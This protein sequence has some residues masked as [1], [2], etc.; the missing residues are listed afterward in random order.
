MAAK[1]YELLYLCFLAFNFGLNIVL[2]CLRILLSTLSFLL[3]L[4]YGVFP[5]VDSSPKEAITVVA[6]C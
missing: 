1:D 5:F 6:S 3:M 4:L 2:R